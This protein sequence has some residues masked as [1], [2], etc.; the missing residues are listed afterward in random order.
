MGLLRRCYQLSDSAIVGEVLQRELEGMIFWNLV[1][2]ANPFY[3]VLISGSN[4][5]GGFNKQYEAGLQVISNVAHGMQRW[6][7]KSPGTPGNW[8]RGYRRLKP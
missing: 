6:L 8:E 1:G 2:M 7:E 4:W 3:F 5:N